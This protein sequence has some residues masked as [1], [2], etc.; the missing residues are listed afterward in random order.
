[1]GWN[2]G[3]IT[4]FKCEDL[5]AALAARFA[6]RLQKDAGE[7]PA[8]QLTRAWELAFSRPPSESESGAAREFLSEQVEQLRQAPEKTDAK[9][10]PLPRPDPEL[11]ALTSLCQTLLSANEFLY[12]D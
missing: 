6:R 3:L 4:F 5:P 12:V 7:D 9:G 2:A 10:K 11:Q 1:M 8:R